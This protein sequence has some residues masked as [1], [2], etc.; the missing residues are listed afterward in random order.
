MVATL[1]SEVL[2]VAPV[3]A[4]DDPS[5]SMSL[6]VLTPS[7]FLLGRR[8]VCDLLQQSVSRRINMSMSMSVCL[9]IEIVVP[10]TIQNRAAR[11]QNN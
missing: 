6:D 9:S 8:T 3:P 4:V 5:V 2:E 7:F 11:N 1:S 10:A